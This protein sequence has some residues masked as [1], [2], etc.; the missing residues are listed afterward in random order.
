MLQTAWQ[1]AGCRCR[2]QLLNR[3]HPST[4]RSYT[5]PQKEPR[6]ARLDVLPHFCCAAATVA[7]DAS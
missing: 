6:S 7:S 4:K 1:D 3:G 5:T 2:A